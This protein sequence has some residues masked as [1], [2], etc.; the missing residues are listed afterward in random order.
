MQVPKKR[1]KYGSVKVVFMGIEM[2]SRLEA[3][4]GERLELHKKAGMI[5]KW[6]YG[7]KYDLVVNGILVARYELD[8][9]TE[10]QGVY[11]YFDTKGMNGGAAMAMFRVKRKLMKALYG[12]DVREAR[13]DYKTDKWQIK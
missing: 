8:F 6:E 3:R 5:D 9:R 2:K 12:I 7:I 11:H 1:S 4:F 10:K 13:Y